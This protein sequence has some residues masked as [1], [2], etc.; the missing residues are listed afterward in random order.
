MR[1]VIT[2]SEGFVG[3]KLKKRLKDRDLFFI[4]KASPES[5]G[6]NLNNSEALE[7][8][9]NSIESDIDKIIEKLNLKLTPVNFNFRVSK[10]QKNVYLNELNFFF[11]GEKLMEN[12]YDLVT[13]YLKFLKKF[14]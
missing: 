6:I 1:I 9:F 4:D 5:K 8:Y 3:S 10:D 2:G 7:K 13:P 12:D 11:G 14:Y